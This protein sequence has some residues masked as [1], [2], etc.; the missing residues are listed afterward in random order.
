MPECPGI[1][2]APSKKNDT[3]TCRI[4]EICC[5]RLAPMRLGPFSY[6]CTCLNVRPSASPSFSCD[7]LN[8][9]RRMRTRDPTCLSIGLGVFLAIKVSYVTILKRNVTN[10]RIYATRDFLYVDCPRHRGIKLVHIFQLFFTCRYLDMFS[11][12]G[13]SIASSNNLDQILAAFAIQG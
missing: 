4:L 5:R 1:F 2:G 11:L 8:I 9:I 7:M 10:D 3:G 6:F 12:I 13:K